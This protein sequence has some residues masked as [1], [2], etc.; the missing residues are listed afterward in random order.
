MKIELSISDF[1][2]EAVVCKVTMSQA[3]QERAEQVISENPS[4]MFELGDDGI[5][6][7]TETC[8]GGITCFTFIEDVLTMSIKLPNDLLEEVV[9]VNV[10]EEKELYDRVIAQTWMLF[11]PHLK[12]FI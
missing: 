2:G 5:S 4:P 8:I 11:I 1:S 9:A 10:W 6:H 12:M 7:F 3:Q